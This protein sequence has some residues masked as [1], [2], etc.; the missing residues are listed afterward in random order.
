MCNSCWNCKHCINDYYSTGTM[1]CKLIDN[2]EMTEEEIE[3]Y[4]TN[5]G[6]ENCIYHEELVDVDAELEVEAI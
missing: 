6:G 2:G 3:D 1:D 5:N 4:Y